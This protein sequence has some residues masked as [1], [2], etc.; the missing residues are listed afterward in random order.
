MLLRKTTWFR[1][2]GL[3]AIS[4]VLILSVL[5][6]SDT[7]SGENAVSKTGMDVYAISEESQED[8]EEIINICKDLY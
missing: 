2:S 5:G 7:P 3:A 4:F 1:K 8:T 6:C